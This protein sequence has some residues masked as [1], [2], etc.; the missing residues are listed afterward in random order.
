[1]TSASAVVRTCDRGKS[2]GAAMMMILCDHYRTD[3]AICGLFSPHFIIITKC[4]T[5]TNIEADIQVHFHS[6]QFKQQ[7]PSLPDTDCLI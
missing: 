2:K 3:T 6:T 1:M 4:H 5:N 7:V